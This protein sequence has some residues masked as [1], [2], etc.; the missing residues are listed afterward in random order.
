MLALEKYFNFGFGISKDFKVI[1]FFRFNY[2]L[3]VFNMFQLCKAGKETAP[4]TLQLKTTMMF[5]FSSFSGLPG[6]DWVVLP[7][8]VARS[9]SGVVWPT[10]T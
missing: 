2:C 5:S 7:F 9:E 10:F 1:F 3:I 8:G 6:L 4:E